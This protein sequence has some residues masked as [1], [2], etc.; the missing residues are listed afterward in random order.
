V[1]ERLAFALHALL[2]G[3]LRFAGRIERGAADL[4]LTVAL[5]GPIMMKEP[6]ACRQEDGHD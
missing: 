1:T 3:D 5:V 6:P 2:A 4:D